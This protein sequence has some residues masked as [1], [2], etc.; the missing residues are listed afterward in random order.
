MAI[1]VTSIQEMNFPLEIS[2]PLFLTVHVSVSLIMHWIHSV[3]CQ[4]VLIH[5]AVTHVEAS[6]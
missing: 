4:F 2:I 1:A 3:A 5:G 6:I